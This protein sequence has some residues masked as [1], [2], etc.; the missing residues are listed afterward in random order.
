MSDELPRLPG[1]KRG[2][3]FEA[4]VDYDDSGTP[5]TFPASELRS[6]VRTIAGELLSDLTITSTAT[7]GRYMLRQL[8]TT[9]WPVGEVLCDVKRL[10]GGVSLY[11]QTFVIPVFRRITV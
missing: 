6:S 5:L 11:T 10:T 7:P 2:Q 8:D 3:S 1:V 9:H 4:Y